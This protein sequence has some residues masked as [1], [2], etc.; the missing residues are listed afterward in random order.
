MKTKIT[1][2]TELE[3]ILPSLP[4]F[5]RTANKDVV[6]PI[7]DL[8][9]E[10]IRELGSEWTE[11]LVQKAIQRRKQKMQELNESLQKL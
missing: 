2:K 8:S 3:I 6:M 5:V 9:N 10:Q 7:G 11:Q 4:N 1:V